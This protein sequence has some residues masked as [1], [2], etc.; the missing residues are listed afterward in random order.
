M[1]ATVGLIASSLFIWWTQIWVWLT[2]N[3][4]NQYL[5]TFSSVVI[6]FLIYGL[7][8][9]LPKI[10]D[11]YWRTI[12][13]KEVQTLWAE[14]EPTYSADSEIGA[15]REFLLNDK[16]EVTW[17][18]FMKVVDGSEY[19]VVDIREGYGYETGRIP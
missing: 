1:F 12:I 10:R 11:A 16:N 7:A 15:R 4:K 8:Y 9:E 3:K 19:L 14:H 17:S 18:D 13:D 6:L 5:F 2:A